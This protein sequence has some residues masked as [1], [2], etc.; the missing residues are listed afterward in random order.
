MY[1]EE[2]V[3]LNVDWLIERLI[4][5]PKYKLEFTDIYRKTTLHGN[6]CAKEV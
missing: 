5:E 2:D 1:Y 3:M 4:M 6:M